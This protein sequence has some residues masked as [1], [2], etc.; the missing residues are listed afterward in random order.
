[1]TP[2]KK[3]KRE[4]LAIAI[5]SGYI[6]DCPEMTDESVDGLYESLL[7]EEGLHWDL[8]Y[9][10]REGEYKTGIQA[11]FSRSYGS[12]SV[13]RKMMDGTWVGWTY[14]YGGGKHGEPET[15]EWMQHAYELDVTEKQ[16]MVTVR[17]F[18]KKTD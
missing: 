10:Y 12:D 8:E 1:M 7:V 16:E 17:E 3:I 6:E 13:A 14:W 2:E 15:I 4:I 18:Q 5:S 9:E 11:P